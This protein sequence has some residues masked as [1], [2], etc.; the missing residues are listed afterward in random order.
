MKRFKLQH[1]GFVGMEAVFDE[2]KAPDWLTSKNTVPGS[3]L[4]MRWFWE[5][6]VLTLDVNQS[7]NTDFHKIIRIK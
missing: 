1:R 3:T 4:D 7:V 5:E 2:N 6:H